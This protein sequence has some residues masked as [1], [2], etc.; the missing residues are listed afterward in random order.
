MPAASLSA[1]SASVSASLLGKA[2][3]G[4]GQGPSLK[5]EGGKKASPL[6]REGSM[7]KKDSRF[8]GEKKAYERRLLPLPGGRGIREKARDVSRES[9]L[10]GT[11]QVYL[12]R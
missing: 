12:A 4:T 5:C 8:S 2:L 11:W 9:K 6:G 3:P 1:S 10:L 7:L